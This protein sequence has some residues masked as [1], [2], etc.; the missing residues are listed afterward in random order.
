MSD[1]NPKPSR[2]QRRAA[3][4][5]LA[6]VVKDESAPTHARVSA[7]RILLNTADKRVLIA[8]DLGDNVGEKVHPVVILPSN[9]REHV[10]TVFGFV[11]GASIMIYRTPAEKAEIDAGLAG[12]LQLTGP[13]A[14]TST[15]RSRLRRERL[16]AEAAA[17]A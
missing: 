8:N 7:S 16:R 1:D 11:E 15:E 5:V 9:G 12:Q 10:D 13:K 4:R 6:K 17:A 3:L 2:Q 14:K